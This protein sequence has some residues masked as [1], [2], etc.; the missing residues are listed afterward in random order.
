M[1]TYNKHYRYNPPRRKKQRYALVERVVDFSK[2]P[3][4]SGLNSEI[5]TAWASG[6][7]LQAIQIRAGQTVL[8]VIVEILKK[9]SVAKSR[10]II[11]TGVQNDLWGSIDLN[12]SIG[13]GIRSSAQIAERQDVIHQNFGKPIYFGSADTVDITLNSILTDGKIRIIVHLLEDDR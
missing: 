4:T 6:D 1:A 13:S 7:I 11:G 5:N 8:G 12:A 3:W 10:I 9:S 2:S